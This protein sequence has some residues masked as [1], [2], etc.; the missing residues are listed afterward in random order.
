VGVL[1]P[2]NFSSSRSRFLTE[3]AE[4][5]ATTG[6]T[7]MTGAAGGIMPPNN[8]PI[9]EK[10]ALIV[11]FG[12]DASITRPS[13]NIEVAAQNSALFRSLIDVWYTVHVKYT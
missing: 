13:E 11:E 1:L 2:E 12:F 9:I 7:A 4:T 10:K 6:S 8:P 3:L 5:F